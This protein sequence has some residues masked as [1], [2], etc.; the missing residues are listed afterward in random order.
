[1]V[2]PLLTPIKL[3]HLTLKN[4]IVMAPT[5][6]ALPLDERIEFLGRVADGGAALI[7]IGDMGVE[8]L[9]YKTDLNLLSPLGLEGCRR[10]IERLHRGGAMAGAQLYLWDYDMDGY[11]RLIKAHAPREQLS[12]Y[13]DDNLEEYINTMPAERIEEIIEHFAKAARSAR[14]V[15]F[16]M[17]QILG[18]HVLNSF[19]SGYIN[20]RTDSFGGDVDRRTELACRVVRAVREA[21]GDDYAIEYKLAT[22]DD[23]IPCGQG[24]P[25]VSE[26]SV[27]VPALERAGVD[28]F[29]A[30]LSN[31]VN[32]E[33]TVPPK[34]HP[35]FGGEGCFLYVS[36]EIKRHTSLPVSC[37]GKLSDPVKNEALIADGRLDYIAMSRQLVADPEWVKKVS[38]GRS[39]EI[40][41]CIFC[42]KGCLGSLLTRQRFHCVL[43]KNA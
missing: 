13:K 7:Y 36:D 25:D 35:V 26:I 23:S 3:G 20:H 43:D 22:H 27:F 28:A 37:A 40:R 33:D 42:N 8:P 12:A 30:A 11:E 19:S 38:E 18:G 41:R 24:G 29:Q 9:F 17:V 39:G 32:L 2:N 14:E 1:M 4:R 5:S 15:G 31:R 34:N 10:V 21:V 16:D 6:M